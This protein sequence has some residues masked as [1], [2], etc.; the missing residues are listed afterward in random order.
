MKISQRDVA[1][2]DDLDNALNS[3]SGYTGARNIVIFTLLLFIVAGVW[4]WYG[5]LDEV[6]TGTGKVIPSSR[7]QVLQSLDGGILAE[8]NVR[9][10]AQ[11]QAGQVLARLDPTR[12]ESNVGESAAR[13]RASLASSIRLT[14]EVNDQ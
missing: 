3:E 5:I 4:A 9:E 13:Y 10:G 11:V 2:M 14:A 6:S 7:E 12:S 1:A 8:L